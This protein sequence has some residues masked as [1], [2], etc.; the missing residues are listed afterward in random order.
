MAEI[1]RL[2]EI[3]FS[4]SSKEVRTL[5]GMEWSS[6]VRWGKHDRIGKEPLLEYGGVNT[7]TITLTMYF[8]KFCGVEPIQEMVRLL[9]I[10]RKG[11]ANRLVIGSHA[12]GTN[13]WVIASSSRKMEYFDMYGN[14]LGA[15]VQIVL[16]S[17][18]RR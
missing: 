2:G 8:S 1:G 9:G 13:K 18:G 16:T 4:V 12:Y 6:S 3:R 17:Y 10:E 5:Q 14:V 7:D 11:E 15:S